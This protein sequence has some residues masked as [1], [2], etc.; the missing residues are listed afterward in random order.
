MFASI[1]LF[2]VFGIKGWIYK[3]SPRYLERER[4]GWDLERER[5]KDGSLCL[6][7]GVIFL[8]IDLGS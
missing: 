4:K 3:W 8:A 6:C 1:K 2:T 5:E 7:I